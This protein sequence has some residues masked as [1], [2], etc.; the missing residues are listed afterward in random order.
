MGSNVD[1]QLKTP[2][3]YAL[4]QVAVDQDFGQMLPHFHR[5]VD[6]QASFPV[7]FSH[8]SANCSAVFGCLLFVID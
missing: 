7:S 1:S 5:L 2:P 3:Q 6:L 8:A 4:K